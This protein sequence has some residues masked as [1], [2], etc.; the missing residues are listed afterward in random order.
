MTTGHV[1]HPYLG[2]QEIELN[3]V[4]ASQ[5]HATARGGVVIVTVGAGTPA[6]AAGL[7]PRDIITAIDGTPITDES[8]FAKIINSHKVGDT[9]TLTVVRA[10]QNSEIPV[11]LAER[12]GGQ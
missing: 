12:P 8:T 9:L 5:L 4:I 2:I 11:T 3:P 7:Q 10:G 1:V 6:A